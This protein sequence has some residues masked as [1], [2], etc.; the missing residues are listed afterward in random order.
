MSFHF[1]RTVLIVTFSFLLGQG[2]VPEN[3][4]VKTIHGDTHKRTEA[5]L[6]CHAIV[7]PAGHLAEIA[8][9]IA[10]T[11]FADHLT[12]RESGV[13]LHFRCLL[14]PFRF[15]GSAPNRYNL[16]YIRF[17]GPPVYGIRN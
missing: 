6:N 5:K 17:R 11:F 15:F 4:H 1:L 16:I 12:L 2:L 3:P 14:Y 13:F 8:R 10:K 7:L 9:V